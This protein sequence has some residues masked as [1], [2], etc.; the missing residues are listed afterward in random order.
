METSPSTEM[1]SLARMKK[2]AEDS[3]DFTRKV[4][5]PA[6]TRD[7]NPPRLYNVRI[8]PSNLVSCETPSTSTFEWNSKHSQKS[9]KNGNSD[10]K[11]YE[12]L[13]EN[14]ITFLDPFS[15]QLRNVQSSEERNVLF[16]TDFVLILIHVVTARQ[17]GSSSLANFNLDT[18]EPFVSRAFLSVPK[19]C[20]LLKLMD[21]IGKDETCTYSAG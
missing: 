8:V 15:S 18:K 1:P 16:E 19:S 3:D 5:K 7:N 2:H 11:H 14:S 21:L 20:S 13:S 17:E 4:L 9:G 6:Y 10:V 12:S